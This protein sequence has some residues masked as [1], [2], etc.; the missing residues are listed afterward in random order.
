VGA[1][2]CAGQAYALLEEF[3]RGVLEAFGGPAEAPLY[4]RMNALA[5]D[6]G[7]IGAGGPGPLVDTRFNGT[8]ED[9]RI[10]GS[11]GGITLHNLTPAAM[12]RAFLAG[13]AGEL[14]DRYAALLGLRAAAPRGLVGSGNGLRRNPALRATISRLFGLPLRL[15]QLREEAALGAALSAAVGLGCYPGF[16]AAGQIIRYETE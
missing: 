12:V 2:L 11:I 6:P 13:I 4:E 15:P 10:T 9:P 14:Y 16:R 5:G 1:T 8:R 7:Q 3:F